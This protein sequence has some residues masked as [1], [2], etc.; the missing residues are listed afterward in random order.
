MAAWPRST[1]SLLLRRSSRGFMFVVRAA[2]AHRVSGH[3]KAYR[4]NRAS[5]RL[6]SARLRVRLSKP[7][8]GLK[9][10]PVARPDWCVGDSTPL[11]SHLH[12]TLTSP[13]PVAAL[14]RFDTVALQAH[15]AGV[16]EHGRS[17]HA[18]SAFLKGLLE[19]PA[20][21]DQFDPAPRAIVDRKRT[22]TRWPARP[23]VAG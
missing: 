1:R 5:E 11:N 7:A 23:R 17:V 20:R 16:A 3:R 21:A 22:G 9:A 4:S 14:D 15:I 13:G 2:P 8:L 18:S 19:H 10:D 12:P 6:R